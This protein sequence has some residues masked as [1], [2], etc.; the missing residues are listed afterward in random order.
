MLDHYVQEMT[1]TAKTFILSSMWALARPLRKEGIITSPSIAKGTI[2]VSF[3]G[4]ERQ[5][6]S[7]LQSFIGGLKLYR[8]C[9]ENVNSTR[10]DR[11]KVRP[12]LMKSRKNCPMLKSR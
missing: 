2:S 6:S 5:R 1:V 4:S 8:G 11:S 10:I 12:S 7:D 3:A 9:Q